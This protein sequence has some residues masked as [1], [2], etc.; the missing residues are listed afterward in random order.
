MTP[1]LFKAILAMDSY[2]RDPGAGI[3]LTE[4]GASGTQIGSATVGVQ[5][6]YSTNN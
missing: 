1:E 5:S 6:N 4:A 3:N 2:N